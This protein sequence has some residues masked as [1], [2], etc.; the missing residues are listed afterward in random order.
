MDAVIAADAQ[1][2]I[3]VFN[4][5]AEAMFHY[6]ASEMTDK[7]LDMLIPKRFREAHAGDI[8]HFA[9]TG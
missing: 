3:V 4:A 8:C 9:A 2:R 5:A 1:Q 7:P 6:P